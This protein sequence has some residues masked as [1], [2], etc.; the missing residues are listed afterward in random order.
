MARV[1]KR[2]GTKDTK[3]VQQTHLHVRVNAFIA[4]CKRIYT[5]GQRGSS[6][7]MNTFI[8]RD[9]RVYLRSLRYTLSLTITV[10]NSYTIAVGTVW[11]LS[12]P[13]QGQSLREWA[14]KSIQPKPL[15]YKPTPLNAC[16]CCMFVVSTN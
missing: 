5:R 12:A 6:L 15:W 9:K 4:G 14:D 13:A 1:Q 8:S 3:R 11:D 7:E 16:S 2:V 10:S